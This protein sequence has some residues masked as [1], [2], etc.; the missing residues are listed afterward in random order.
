M[1]FIGPHHLPKIMGH[2]AETN[3]KVIASSHQINTLR[4]KE[5]IFQHRT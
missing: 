5:G 3:Y 1:T 2:K 4:E